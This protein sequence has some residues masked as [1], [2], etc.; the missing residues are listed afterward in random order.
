[1]ILKMK[2]ATATAQARDITSNAPGPMIMKK[3][4]RKRVTPI[5]PM[6]VSSTL[7]AVGQLST[8]ESLDEMPLVGL[9][10]EAESAETDYV[11]TAPST[12]SRLLKQGAC[13]IC[14]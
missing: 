12:K 5:K 3:G 9:L 14:W 10:G 11:E 13:I 7:H 4:S 2:S 1:M 6:N 8:S